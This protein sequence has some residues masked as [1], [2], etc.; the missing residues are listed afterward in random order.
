MLKKSKY[1]SVV[2]VGN[3]ISRCMSSLKVA[4]KIRANNHAWRRND[5]FFCCGVEEIHR[6]ELNGFLD[7][8]LWAWPATCTG[9]S[10][11][12]STIKLHTPKMLAIKLFQ[13]CMTGWRLSVTKQ[14]MSPMPHSPIWKSMGSIN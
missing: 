13:T 5:F 6:N 2:G 8:C 3:L 14:L 7:V 1:T 10:T 12:H 9:V 4:Y 11:T